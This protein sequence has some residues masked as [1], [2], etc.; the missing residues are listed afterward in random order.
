MDLDK[1]RARI[2]KELDQ[3]RANL[4]RTEAKLRN[5]KFVSKA[6]EQVIQGVRDTADKTRSL[7][8]RLE[9]SLAGLGG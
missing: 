5:E 1:E 9:E 6:P 7:I 3:A 4:E 2:Q 8:V